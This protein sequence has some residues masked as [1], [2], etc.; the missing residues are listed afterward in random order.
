MMD[1]LT[2][3][4]VF[5]KAAEVGSF[6][7][8]AEQLRLSPQMV[9]KH[10]ASLETRLGTVLLNRTTRRQSLTDVGRNYYERCKVVL[11]EAEEAD[12]IAMEMKSTPSGILKVSAPLTFGA[13]TLAPFITRYLAR[14]TEIQVD[15]EL[16]DRLVEPF[17]EGYEV[18]IRIGELT[19]SSLV[20]Y[21]LKP[22]R[23]IACASPTYLARMG[24]PATPADLMDNVCLVY[25]IWSPSMPCRWH[26]QRAG[27]VEEVKPQG[28]FRSNDWKALLH[29]ALEGHGV[30]LG[31]ADVLNEEIEKGRL[32]QILPEYDGPARPMNMLIPAGR[33]QTVKIRSFVDAINQTFG[34]HRSTT[35]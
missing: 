11:A 1:R 34:L 28:R 13:F 32:I 14:Y 21:P 35:D 22:Y 29:A 12:A 26:F 18:V 4:N 2:S 10:I 5:V 16:S 3:M 19:D 8:A 31:P 23:L 20:A 30:T 24:M 33:R 27:R 15:L 17:E 6:A 9:A 7:A 25:G